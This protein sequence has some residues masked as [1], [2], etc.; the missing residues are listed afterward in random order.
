MS[1]SFLLEIEFKIKLLELR[2]VAPKKVSILIKEKYFEI[3]MGDIY[4]YLFVGVL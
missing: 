1:S 4:V 2:Q 3:K